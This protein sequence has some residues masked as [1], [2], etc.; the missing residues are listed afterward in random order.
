MRKFVTAC[1]AAVAI[2]SLSA[3]Y[4]GNIRHVNLW[5][6]ATGANPTAAANFAISLVY[7]RC[8]QLP[9]GQIVGRPVLNVMKTGS[10]YSATASATCQ[11][12]T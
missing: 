6:S 10:I 7:S 8:R 11:H 2:A 12:N 5:Q 3:A 1:V 9:G 4:A